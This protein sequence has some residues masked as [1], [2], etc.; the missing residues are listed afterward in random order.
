MYTDVN[1]IITSVLDVRFK[2]TKPFFL[3][4]IKQKTD[5]RK[6]HWLNGHRLCANRPADTVIVRSSRPTD[7]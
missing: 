2:S 6:T 5:V 1:I 3:M 4:Y 7:S